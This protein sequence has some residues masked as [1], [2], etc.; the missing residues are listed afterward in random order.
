VPPLRR[1]LP[2][3]GCM[4]PSGG[5][6]RRPPVPGVNDG[7]GQAEDEVRKGGAAGKV[8]VLAPIPKPM[9]PTS[10]RMGGTPAEERVSN[11]LNGP[12]VSP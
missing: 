9:P 8:I 3:D 6:L 11:L 10:R 4:R 12:G 1:E 5:G 2:E 7:P